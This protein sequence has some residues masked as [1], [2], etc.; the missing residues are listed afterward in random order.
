[1]DKT[2]NITK[3]Q[4][5][6]KT[7]IKVGDTVKVHQRIKE[8]NKE[9]IQI[10]EGL[11]I[12]KKHGEGISG[13]FTVR[14][15]ASGVGVEKVFPLH[16]PMIEKIEV[17]KSGKVRRAKIYYIR[18]ATGRRGRLKEIK[19]KLL[20]EVEEE[21]VVEKKEA[22]S[23]EVEKE[24]KEETKQENETVNEE[25]VKDKEEEKDQTKKEETTDKEEQKEDSENKK[26]EK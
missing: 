13:T 14:K 8:G 20:P 3:D 24:T 18:E 11:I 15:V 12:A 21:E 9:R 10:F 7:Q 2:A 4:L 6:N 17:V 5:K 25:D 19:R 16:A 23:K 22:V 1:M 26:E